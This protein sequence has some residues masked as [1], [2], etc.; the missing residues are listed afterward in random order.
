[1]TPRTMPSAASSAVSTA[2]TT[3]TSSSGTTVTKL[4][5]GVA[6]LRL[7]GGPVGK[8]PARAARPTAAE[9]SASAANAPAR[10]PAQTTVTADQFKNPPF[11]DL[12][13][14][15][16]SREVIRAPAVPMTHDV[17]QTSKLKE[18]ASN[19]VSEEEV[20]AQ[21]KPDTPEQ[22]AER[23]IH[24][25]FMRE[26]LDMVCSPCTFLLSPPLLAAFAWP[27]FCW[28][29]NITSR[30]RRSCRRLACAFSGLYMQARVVMMHDGQPS[31]R[32]RRVFHCT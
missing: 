26:A 8:G 1:M 10:A 23:A 30:R 15:G 20:L 13:A 6:N 2:S 7:E 32:T 3:A 31:W 24:S 18:S 22:A 27:W 5:N 17:S 11:L 12:G 28:Y 16:A 4:S 29:H 21:I 25:G 14:N 19:K 9:N